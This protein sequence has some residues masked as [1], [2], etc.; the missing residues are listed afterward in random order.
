MAVDRDIVEAAPAKVNL[1]LHVTGRRDDGYHLLDSIVVFTDIGDTVRV[2]PADALSLDIDGPFAAGLTTGHDNLVVRAAHLLKSTFGVDAGAEISLRKNLPVASGIG[3][4]SADAAA[5]LRA[6]CRLW[7]IDASDPGVRELALSLG[8]DVP[9]C[10]AGRPARMRGIGEDLNAIPPLPRLGIVLVN[11][12]VGVATPAVFKARRAPFSKPF[13]WPAETGEQHALV[14]A[15]ARSRND[16]E[17]PASELAPVIDTVLE[18]LRDPE[19]V[20][21]ARMS[22]SGATCFALT[23]DAE[24]AL[25]VAS[26]VRNAHPDWWAA[27]GSVLL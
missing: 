15:V 22:G 21:V 6:L 13:V 12:G 14:H 26:A 25:S 3:G 24:T 20:L 9:V 16:L 11:P 23:E 10:L 7:D 18:A 1:N 27:G 4:G 5:T 8:A 2:R 19:G 17:A